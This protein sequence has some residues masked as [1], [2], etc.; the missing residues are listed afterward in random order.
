MMLWVALVCALGVRAAGGQMGPRDVVRAMIENEN[1][2]S[3]EAER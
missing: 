3:A 1:R 2:A